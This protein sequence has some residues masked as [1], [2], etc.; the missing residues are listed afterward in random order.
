ML[1]WL[2]QKNISKTHYAAEDLWAMVILEKKNH[3]QGLHGDSLNSP[4]V[5]N[6]ALVKAKRLWA[7]TQQPTEGRME[8]PVVS[9]GT[10][11]ALKLKP[12]W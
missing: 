11:T 1:L 7:M 4:E 5:T 10:E 9:Q 8:P 2:T 6:S 12:S 3:Q